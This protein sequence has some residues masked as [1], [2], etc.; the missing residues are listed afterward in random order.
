MCNTCSSDVVMWIDVRWRK[1]DLRVRSPTE[2][3]MSSLWVKVAWSGDTQWW[4]QRYCRIISMLNKWELSTWRQRPR[5]IYTGLF[6]H[7]WRTTQH[8]KIIDH[9]CSHIGVHVVVPSKWWVLSFCWEMNISSCQLIATQEL[10]FG[11]CSSTKQTSETQIC[12]WNPHSSLE[13]VPKNGLQFRSTQFVTESYT[14]R[15]CSI[16]WSLVYTE[17]AEWSVQAIKETMRQQ[18]HDKDSWQLMDYWLALILPM[19]STIPHRNTRAISSWDTN[20]LC[21]QAQLSWCKVT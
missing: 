21:L 12:F 2:V 14:Q 7:S 18:L 20:R 13:L 19:Y 15:V 5:V 11:L 1:S 16:T 17:E 8:F 9:R 10:L 4:L 3:A 6:L